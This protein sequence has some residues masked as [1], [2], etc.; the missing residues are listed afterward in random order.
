MEFMQQ[1]RDNGQPFFLH[2][3]LPKPHQCYTPAQEFWDLYD[4][5]ELNLPPNADNEDP[6]EA[7]HIRAMAERM[8][9]GDWTLFEPKTFEAGRRRKLQ[10][11]L[12]NVS[13]VDY[14]V[15]ELVQWLDDNG[16]G[17]DTIVVYTSDHGDYATEHGL[18]EKAPGICH[19]AI[20][21]V[22]CLWRWT[23]QFQAG[24]VADELVEA[25]D[26][27][28]TLARLCGLPA[29]ETGDGQD[30]RHLLRGEQGAVR[31]VAVTEFSWSKSVRKGDW[32]LVW[33]PPAMFADEY[34][35]GF[36]QLYNLKED[37]WEQRNRY[38]DDD[39]REKVEELRADLIT[40]LVT[41]T[42]PTTTLG[43]G[44]PESDQTVT[45]YKHTVNRDGRFN[46]ALIPEVTHKNYR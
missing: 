29:L 7:P 27:P 35:D 44:V 25:V 16:L 30:I 10:G 1:A 33:Y 39:C 15:G 22:P 42:R 37:P 9:K 12:G 45:R 11:Y 40:W 4:G 32:R 3:S 17:E 34:P 31:D 2:V 38:F 8:R 41:T 14:A 6:H 5:D 20:T 24:H 43:P 28:T 26:V 13:H 18:M 46:P 36:G 19:D 21:R 23:G